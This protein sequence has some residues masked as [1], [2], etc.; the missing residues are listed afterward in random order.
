MPNPVKKMPFKKG[1]GY[2]QIRGQQN[3]QEK[4]DSRRSLNQGLDDEG[5]IYH[6]EEESARAN[7]LKKR[8]MNK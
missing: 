8:E 5:G 7:F 1:K 3:T 6:A 2:E 4:N